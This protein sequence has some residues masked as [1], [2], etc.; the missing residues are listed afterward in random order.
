MHRLIEALRRRLRPDRSAVFAVMLIATGIYT[1]AIGAADIGAAERTAVAPIV[2]ERLAL[3]P[4]VAKVKWNAKRPVE[5][6]AREAE[7]IASTTADLSDAVRPRAERAIRAQIN[8]SKQV[9]KALFA[10]WNAHQQGVFRDV[11]DLD[12]DL[13]PQIALLTTRLIDAVVSGC[14]TKT[15]TDEP[16]ARRHQRAFETALRGIEC[17]R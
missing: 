16:I 14:E 10:Q 17:N 15:P 9:Q 5:D 2:A 12:G 7:L 8:A 13:R 6:L 11:R 3:M 1:T 4:E